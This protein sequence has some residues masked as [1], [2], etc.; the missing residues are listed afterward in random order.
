VVGSASPE[1]EKIDVE[2]DQTWGVMVLPQGLF[3][4]QIY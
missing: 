2:A 1:K 3:V 4:I